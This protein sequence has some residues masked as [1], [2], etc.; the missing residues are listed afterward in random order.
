MM[1]MMDDK[2]RPRSFEEMAEDAVPATVINEVAPE[3]VGV[4]VPG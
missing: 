1:S 3:N 2:Y 4:L